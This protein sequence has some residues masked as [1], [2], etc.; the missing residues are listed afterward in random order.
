[1]GK[2][3]ETLLFSNLGL[4]K[5]ESLAFI[6]D[7]EFASIARPIRTLCA[8]KGVTF[9]AFP[10]DYDGIQAP[11]QPIKDV[12]QSSTWGVILFGVVHNIW[13]T[14][15]RK[16]AKYDLEKRLASIVCAPD[17]MD[18]V[19]PVSSIPLIATACRQFST[20]FTKGAAVRIT[21]PAGC[22]FT[23]T[24]GT[25]FCEHGEYNTPGSG[26]DFPAGEVG[27]G[28]VELS[29]SGRIV[30]DVKVQHLGLLDSPLVLDVERDKIVEVS[31]T[32]REAFLDL[33][34]RR[35]SMLGYISEVSLGLNPF[36]GISGQPEYIPEEKTYG[37]AHCGHGGNAS[38]GS[39]TGPHIDGVIDRP[40]VEIDGT[41]VLA[42]GRVS[43]G[44]IESSILNWL[45]NPLE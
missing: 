28:P 20:S 1:M 5:G 22:N 35:G 14:P 11:P 43:E 31:G 33:I 36:V 2:G 6:H 12:I 42:N 27:F 26:G 19:G 38:Y 25:P 4:K 7:A 34:N 23:A 3:L 8:Q 32:H 9:E 24:I 37:T 45:S 41:I 40:N 29:V 15:E 44:L 39:R 13:H 21:S 18:H 10:I 30:Y 17:R 16:Q